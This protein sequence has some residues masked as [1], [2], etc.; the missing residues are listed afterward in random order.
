MRPRIGLDARFALGDRRG[1]GNYSLE[2]FKAMAHQNMEF[3]FVFYSD[4]EDKDNLLSSLPNSEV[5]VLHPGVYPLWEQCLLPL[6]LL[7]DN[8]ALFHAVGNTAP[9]IL[10]KKTKLV[11]TLCDVMY[12]K[13]EATLPL[14]QS[15]YQRVGRLYRKWVVP[16][17]SRNADLLLTISEFSRIDILETFPSIPPNKIEVTLLGLPAAFQSLDGESFTQPPLDGE[18]YILHL[19]GLDPRKNTA[20]VI[21]SFLELKRSCRLEERLIV[22]GLKNL[23]GL[24]LSPLEYTGENGWIHFP[25]FVPETELPNYY[26]FAEAFLFPSLYEGFGIPLLEAMSCGTPILTSN[27]TSLPE[28][29]GDAALFVDS[30]STDA[31]K[32]ALLHL[33]SSA[34]LKEKMRE[35]GFKRL[36]LFTWKATSTK[37]LAAYRSV[38]ESASLAGLA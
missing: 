5:R 24:G 33:L 35:S 4:R 6:A 27:T 2:L 29:A 16:P 26:R 7:R 11:I 34:A 9:L 38:L 17:A 13:D 21:R 36:S 12:M 32:S 3:D 8:I 31:I 18:P 30:R 28:I 19:G 20:R 15:W 1:I 25:G 22:L 23:E 37:T 10:P 14:S